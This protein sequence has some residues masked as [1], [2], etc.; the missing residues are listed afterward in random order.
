MH[1]DVCGHS[2]GWICAALD[3][4]LSSF[5]HSVLDR[6]LAGCESC[7]AFQAHTRSFTAALREA[8]P[9]HPLRRVT[10]S[11]RRRVIARQSVQA[12]AA[13]LV[14]A[15]VGLGSLPGL[16]SERQD[17]RREQPSFVDREMQALKA[18]QKLVFERQVIELVQESSPS[19]RRT[20]GPQA[21]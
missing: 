16:L 1:P 6:H 17:L 20:P 12:A 10:V 15:A 14:L 5:E 9:E 13:A 11:R 3:G 7:R 21:L 4:E 8:A 2:R 18:R 19:S